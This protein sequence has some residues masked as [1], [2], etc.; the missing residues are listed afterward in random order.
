MNYGKI[1][2]EVVAHLEKVF[3]PLGFK[4]EALP[5]TDAELDRSIS[6]TRP[7][8]TVAYVSSMFEGVSNDARN[9]RETM[10]FAI[11]CR[12]ALLREK[13]GMYEVLSAVKRRLLGFKTKVSAPFWFDKIVIEDTQVNFWMFSIYVKTSTQLTAEPGNENFPALTEIKFETEIGLPNQ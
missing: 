2:N 9:Q 6:P 3:K 11:I 1:E 4:V 8:I 13:S 5:Q 12:A 10:T 7:I